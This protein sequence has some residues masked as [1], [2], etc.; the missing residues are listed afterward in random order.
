MEFTLFALVAG[1][2]LI[3]FKLIDCPRSETALVLGILITITVAFGVFAWAC[4]AIG[5]MAHF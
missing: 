2:A 1:S 5:A 4:R 3:A